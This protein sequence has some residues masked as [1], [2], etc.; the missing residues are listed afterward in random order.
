MDEHRLAGDVQS[1][2][3]GGCDGQVPAVVHANEDAIEVGKGGQIDLRQV[4]AIRVAVEGT[5]D[6]G[7]GVGDHLDL[8]DLELGAGSIALAQLLAAEVVAD[9]GRGQ[10]LVGDQ[11]IVDRVAEVDQ[12]RGRP[13]ACG[14]R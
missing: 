2:E 13:S 12:L 6:V 1:L 11:A 9:D 3:C 8:A 5:I 10:A 7:A 14:A 4:L